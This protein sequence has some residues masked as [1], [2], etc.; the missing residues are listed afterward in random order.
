[1]KFSELLSTLNEESEPLKKRLKIAD[2]AL[3]Y[4]DLPIQKREVFLLKWLIDLES[5]DQNVWQ[6][7]FEWISSNNI[8][9]MSRND[10][11]EDDF[12]YLNNV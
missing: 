3:K 11:N 8:N 6:K 5:D 12:V 1:M 7:L 4:V 9:N 2:N 10:L